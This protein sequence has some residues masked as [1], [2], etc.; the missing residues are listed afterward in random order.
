[1]FNVGG[2]EVMRNVFSRP[3]SASCVTV[4]YRN[5]KHFDDVHTV[6][7]ADTDTVINDDLVEEEDQ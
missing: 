4:N 2:G 3:G 7:I 5:D 1:M 6:E